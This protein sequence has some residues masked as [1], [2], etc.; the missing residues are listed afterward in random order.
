MGAS[1]ARSALPP[2][3]QSVT[4]RHSRAFTRWVSV[5]AILSC[6]LVLSGQAAAGSTWHSDPPA[7]V[8]FSSPELTI[9]RKELSGY[10]NY[11]VVD[12]RA[13]ILYSSE[14]DQWLFDLS[15]L[16]LPGPIQSAQVVLSLVL[17]DHYGIPL[18]DYFG[19]ITV[20]GQQVFSG[21]LGTGLGLQHGTPLGLVFQN[22]QVVT[23]PIADLT[24][25]V[26]AVGVENN[27]PGPVYG[28]WIAL[29]Y[30]ELR[31]DTLRPVDVDIKPGSF[32][33]SINLKSHGKIPVAIL[34]GAAFDAPAQVDRA[35]LTFGRTGDEQ[36]LAFCNPGSEDVN[37][38]GRP[39]L[40]CHF[41]TQETMFQKGDTQGILKGRTISGVPLRG[42]D[43]VRIV[44]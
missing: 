3:H 34:S 9:L 37:R 21:G 4:S 13:D 29:D 7:V 8:V 28:D 14:S 42:V 12:G 18:T 26:Y 2:A 36:S 19:R 31:L 33:N 43:S 39:D 44:P 5:A 24:P 15:T 41:Y 11:G 25:S 23:F 6:V 38:D 35:A 32:P 16:S 30:I 40:V 22:W 17:D 20:N 1:F 27:T 10:A